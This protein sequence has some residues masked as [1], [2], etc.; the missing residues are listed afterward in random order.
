MIFNSESI[1]H[2]TMK[3]ILD[4][5]IDIVSVQRLD[6]ITAFFNFLAGLIAGAVI[7]RA[8]G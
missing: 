4:T 5:D 3:V 2:Y 8:N 1:V 7:N 6:N